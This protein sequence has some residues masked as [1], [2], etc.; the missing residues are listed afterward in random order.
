M[1]IR[2]SV[3]GDAATRWVF[4][5]QGGGS[6]GTL[7][8][9]TIR[10]CGVEK[11]TKTK[12]S[13]RWAQM[14]A[15][16]DGQGLLDRDGENPFADA[17]LV[18]MYYCSSDQWM[19]Q[20]SDSVLTDPDDPSQQYRLHYRGHTI[21][22]AALDLLLAGP[23]TSEDGLAT[24]PSLADATAVLWSGT[25]GGGN[26]AEQNLD[27]VAERLAG[28]GTAVRG[29]FDANLPPQPSD[30]GD[31]AAEEAFESYDRDVQWPEIQT[32]AW[33]AFVDASCRASHPA[34]EQ[35]RCGENEHVVLHHVTTPFFVRQDL[36]DRSIGGRYLDAGAT[37]AQLAT[38]YRATLVRVPDI[39][40]TG[41]EGAAVTVP[42]GVYGPNCGQHVGL[43]NDEWFNQ[44]TVETAGGAALSFRQALAIWLVGGVVTAIDSQPSTVSYC[45]PPVDSGE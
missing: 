4:Y 41:E 35:W 21:I 15:N 24:V 11:Y 23:V 5:L 33:G 45:P 22:D 29:V 31:P 28:N 43:S 27:H 37:E 6:C 16:T 19:G 13:S 38:A 18:L 26:G 34:D 44:G 1:Y 20:K 36:R 42:P 17:N 40:T 7:E 32:A 12:M 25:S 8:Q 2:P 3:G 14:V 39:A 30:L 10:Y 9:C